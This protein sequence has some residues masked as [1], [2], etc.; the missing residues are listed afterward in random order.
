[1]PVARGAFVSAVALSHGKD[2]SRARS[3]RNVSSCTLAFPRPGIVF[4]TP[5]GI[6]S[7]PRRAGDLTAAAISGGVSVIQ[8]RDRT[9][10][11]A[12]L[13]KT[14]EYL[15]DTLILRSQLV[16]NGPRSIEI[17]EHLGGGVGV[18]FRE[19]DID[20]MLPAFAEKAEFAERCFLGC[21]V[22]SVEA[23]LRA[24]S[25]TAG[26]RPSYLQVGTMFATK[27]HPGKIPEGAA[28]LRAIRVAIGPDIALVGVGGITAENL[29]ELV[30]GNPNGEN[31]ADGIALISAI[32]NAAEPGE[33][34][35]DLRNAVTSAW[36][37][38]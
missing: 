10:T 33:A 28:L 29:S 25:F 13:R 15:A 36:N 9:A 4:I 7:D 16:V 22:H 12:S 27:S 35:R 21:S 24:V 38:C 1:M 31:G 2:W 34:A 17:A 11:P 23:A 14:A 6:C 3:P 8:L 26:L 30:V 19:C 18:H 32:A 20:E 37:R 5:N